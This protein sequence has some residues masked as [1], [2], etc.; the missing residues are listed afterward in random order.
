MREHI[1]SELAK[2]LLGPSDGPNEVL[3]GDGPNTKYVTGILA[4]TKIIVDPT[5]L[6]GPIATLPRPVEQPARQA[7]LD[8][9]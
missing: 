5:L 7:P 9:F 2:E 4:P 8:P 3:Q 1:I 6:H